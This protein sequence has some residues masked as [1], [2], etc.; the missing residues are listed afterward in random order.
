MIWIFPKRVSDQIV[1]ASEYIYSR[2]RRV[3]C[4]IPPIMDHPTP[5]TNSTMDIQALLRCVF[6]PYILPVS[7]ESYFLKDAYGSQVSIFSH[8]TGNS[9]EMTSSYIFQSSLVELNIAPLWVT[10]FFP[11]A[12]LYPALM[13]VSEMILIIL[14]C[15]SF[16]RYQCLG[17]VV[18]RIAGVG[19]SVDIIPRPPK[20][21]R[22]YVPDVVVLISSS[23]HSFCFFQS[24]ACEL[25][26][27][28]FR[29]Y[30]LP[31][32]YNVTCIYV[33]PSLYNVTTALNSKFVQH[34]IH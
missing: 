24:P 12:C 20:V 1:I 19:T 29:V 26:P 32:I 27:A 2:G 22:N 9:S 30:F 15:R 21:S 16:S 13:N 18:A 17:A 28:P 14:I 10:S 25:G 6:L 34:L 31:S 3:E 7:P 33:L 5:S 4:A 23:S 8:E 11:V